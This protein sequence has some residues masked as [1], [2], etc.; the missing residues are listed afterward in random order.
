VTA[1]TAKPVPT[2]G[3]NADDLS[4]VVREQCVRTEHERFVKTVSIY[5]PIG[6]APAV[7]AAVDDFY[8]RVLADPELVG[9]FTGVDVD[10]VKAHQRMF[11]AA[12]LGGPAAYRGRPMREVH[13]GLRIR[14][15]DF[16]RVVDHLAATLTTLG[17]PGP[18]VAII[19]D[20]LV[21]LREQIVDEPEAAALA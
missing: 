10:Q 6:G 8:Q 9:Y 7:S 19:A 5:D 14:G 21:P 2:K 3:R 18:T 15:A 4:S 11:I 13:A 12:A 20:V 17:V 16:D 1:V